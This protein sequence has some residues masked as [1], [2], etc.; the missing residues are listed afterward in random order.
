MN[1]AVV[2]TDFGHKCMDALIMIFY[3]LELDSLNKL[4]ELKILVW[5]VWKLNTECASL[6]CCRLLHTEVSSSKNI[7]WPRSGIS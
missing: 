1:I 6:E 3:I 2:V 4:N 5:R 7:T